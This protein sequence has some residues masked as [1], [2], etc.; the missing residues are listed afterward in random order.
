M[1]SEELLLVPNPF[2]LYWKQDAYLFCSWWI[3]ILDSDIY[4]V[5]KLVQVNLIKKVYQS[6]YA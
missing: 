5:K 1:D 3:Q 6:I 2:K 4:S